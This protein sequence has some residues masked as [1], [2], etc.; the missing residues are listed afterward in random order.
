MLNMWF[1][2]F[3]RQKNKYVDLDESVAILNSFPLFVYEYLR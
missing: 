3:E 1:P 2:I